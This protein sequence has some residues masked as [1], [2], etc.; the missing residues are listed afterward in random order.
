MWLDSTAGGGLSAEGIAH[1]KRGS[2]QI[3]FFFKEKEKDSGV[4][5]TFANDKATDSW[6][7]LIDNE[8]A[9]KRTPFA[10]VKLTRK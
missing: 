7:W 1:G 9:G 6:T 3:E 5:T 10:R 2:D 8:D 4:S